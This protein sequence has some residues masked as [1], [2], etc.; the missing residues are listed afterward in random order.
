MSIKIPGVDKVRRM[1]GMERKRSLTSII[2][3][4]GN[5]VSE[6][7]LLFWLSKHLIVT[8]TQ[9]SPGGLVLPNGQITKGEMVIEARLPFDTANPLL[10]LGDFVCMLDPQAI[11]EKMV[12]QAQE[13]ELEDSPLITEATQ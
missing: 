8:V 11:T 3:L 9:V 1:I 10:A 6:G 7:S 2:D 4:A 13:K 12:K 5:H